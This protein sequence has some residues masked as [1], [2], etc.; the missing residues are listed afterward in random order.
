MFGFD[1]VTAGRAIFTL[2]IP[3]SF[4]AQ[5]GTNPHYTFR[6]ERIEAS[7]RWPETFVVKLLTV[8]DNEND[9]SYLGILD[10]QTAQV[11]LTK[12]SCAGEDAWSVRLLRRALACLF[13]NQ[14]QRMMAAG[15][16]LHHEGR[17]GRCG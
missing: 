6:V 2:S 17:C 16:D 9:Y 4:A 7:G 15:F 1:F 10:P 13:H 12:K 3:E 14:T 5:H 11:R 8:H